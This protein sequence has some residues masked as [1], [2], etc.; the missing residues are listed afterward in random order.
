MAVKTNFKTEDFENIFLNYNLG[1]LLSIEPC[2]NGTVQTNYFLTT[3]SGKYV[4]RYY[5]NRTKESVLFELE[6]LNHLIEKNY[7]CPALF[8][9]K[10]GQF[11]GI[12]KDK[13]FVIF[14]FVEGEHIDHPNEEQI[15]QLIRKIAKLHNITVGFQPEMTQYRLNYNVEQCKRLVWEQTEKINTVNAREKQKWY[16]NQIDRLMLPESLPSGVCHCDFHFSNAL[17][18]NG[19]FRCLIDFDDANYTFLAYDLV[20]MLEPFKEDF[21][22]D[23]WDKFGVDE[24]VFDFNHAR[25][26][27]YEYSKYRYLDEDEKIH[28]FD[29]LKFSILIDCIWYFER[30]DVNDFFE[31]RKIDYLNKLGRENFY[32]ELFL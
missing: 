25:K 30:G 20:N 5:E 4:F 28:L 10:E 13:P 9:N 14:S 2:T 8:R 7:P 23:T 1:K 24:N 16:I 3:T 27:V 29:L 15:K 6:V 19:K 18:Y 26:V 17:Y 21:D 22:W 31:K 32:K 12:Y 11:I